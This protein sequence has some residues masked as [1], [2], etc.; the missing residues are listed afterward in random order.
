MLK[1][2]QNNLSGNGVKKWKLPGVVLPAKYASTLL[3]RGAVDAKRKIDWKVD[4]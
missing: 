4:A 2:D 3:I 1:S